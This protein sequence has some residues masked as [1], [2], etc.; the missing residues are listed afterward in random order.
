VAAKAVGIEAGAYTS[1]LAINPSANQLTI[2][3]AEKPIELATYDPRRLTG[4]SVYREI[5]T[6]VLRR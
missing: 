1:V 3:K 2:E 6:R 5:R 4:V